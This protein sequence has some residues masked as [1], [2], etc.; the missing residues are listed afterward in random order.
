MINIKHKLTAVGAGLIGLIGKAL[1]AENDTFTPNLANGQKTLM[2]LQYADKA[3]LI[4]D[5]LYAVINWAAVVALLVL[6]IK[7]L[8]GGWDSLEHE[9]RS[10][11]AIIMIVLIILALK[12]GSCPQ[13]IELEF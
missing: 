8:L 11:H 10:R 13:I 6:V 9:I 12:F 4:I 2:G 7:F 3:K 1:A 5:V